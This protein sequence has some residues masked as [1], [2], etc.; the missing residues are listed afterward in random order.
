MG[1]YALACCGGVDG[2]AITH[3]DRVGP[4]WQMCTSYRGGELKPGPFQDLEYQEILTRLL[5]KCEPVYESFDLEGYV[6]ALGAPLWF[7]SWGAGSNH[8][9][10]VCSAA[11][12]EAI[13]TPSA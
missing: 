5:E 9:R 10:R 11:T 3:L 4:D 8:K 6:A 7:E 2:L 12:K 13:V 1:R